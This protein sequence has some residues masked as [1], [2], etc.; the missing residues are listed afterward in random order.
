[1]RNKKIDNIYLEAQSISG[2]G[3]C[4]GYQAIEV[5]GEIY[6]AEGNHSRKHD[7]RWDLIDKADIRHKVVLDLGCNIGGM[8]IGA[9]QRG[10]LWCVGIE[11]NQKI[12][13]KA[14]ELVE[15]IG[16]ENITYKCA[17]LNTY[18]VEYKA[19]TVFLFSVWSHL[20][21]TVLLKEFLKSDS[22]STLY[23]EGHP[24][25]PI[26]KYN[27]LF[28]ELSLTHKFLGYTDNNMNDATERPFFKCKR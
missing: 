18:S 4:G 26:D 9:A 15:V 3:F 11:V 12:L 27:T 16:Y 17:D 5:N 25:E 14:V 7:T 2:S 22:F 1:M 20:T 24:R 10:A 19:N 13:N 6:C 23:F 21:D 28:E 8:C